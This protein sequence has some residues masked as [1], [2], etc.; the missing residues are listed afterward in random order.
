MVELER[1]PCKD[2]DDVAFK[3]IFDGTSLAGWRMCGPGSFE[4]ENNM[5][6]SKGGM[7]LLWYAR[8][9]F[10]N[11][12]LRVLWKTTRKDDNSG[13]FV[14]FIDPE[15][16]P[17]IAVNTGYEIQ[18]YDG[19]QHQGNA[20]HKTGAIY[21]FAAPSRHPAT[22]PGEWNRFDIHAVG[23]NYLVILNNIRITEFIGNRR[24]DGYIGLQN[25]DAES[26]VWFQRVK[27]REL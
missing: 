24:T 9:K 10:R 18:I 16:D 15:N 1:I 5:I 26:R 8:K 4:L 2:N 6:V 19:E 21:G 12:I 23:Q 22:K 27:I 14:R 13:I 20:T 3:N 25:H 17:W 7:G 11:F